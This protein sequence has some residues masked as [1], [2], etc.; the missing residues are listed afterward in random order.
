M[1]ILPMS[2]RF[3]PK[4]P[5]VQRYR[6][7]RALH[8]I[9]GGY[10]RTPPGMPEV[11][12]PDEV[13]KVEMT[14]WVQIMSFNLMY[15]ANHAITPELWR[16]IHAFNRAF[17]NQPENGYDGGIPLA[18]FINTRDI[19]ARFPSYDKAQRVCGGS[20]IT[21]EAVSDK[22]VCRAGVDGIDADSP[23][24]DVKTIMEKH[25]FIHAVS[26]NADGRQISHFPQGKG[27]PVLIPFIFRGTITFPLAY[28]ERWEADVLPNPLK[29]YRGM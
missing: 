4:V 11:I 28:F 9:E 7:W 23:M 12:P 1:P 27:G 8:K 5:E 3:E 26:I 13:Q 17:N 22:L 15:E 24:P 10:Q 16:K 20:F 29:L 18:D 21:G 25:W 6:G 2:L 19:D 14:R